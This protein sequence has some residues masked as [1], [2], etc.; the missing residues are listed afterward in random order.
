MLT[1]TK[2]LDH[3]QLAHIKLSS[4]FANRNKFDDGDDYD[5]DDVDDNL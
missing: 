5:D 1:T 2:K 3:H 4:P